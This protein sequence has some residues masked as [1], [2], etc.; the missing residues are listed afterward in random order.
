[1]DKNFIK[2][3]NSKKFSKNNIKTD[4]RNVSSG[5]VF[6]A[7]KG[8]AHDG[9]DH[10][11]EVIK[12]G[13]SCVICEHSLS[14]LDEKD[15]KKIIVTED[16]REALACLAKSF[17]NDPSG[18]L[19]TVGVTGTNGKT[20]TVF[21]LDSI[22][23]MAGKKCGMIS[24]VY[25]KTNGDKLERS[26]MTTPDI[27]TTNRLLEEMVQNGKK[28]AVIEMSSHALDQKRVWGIELDAAIFTNITPEHLD[29]HKN[30]ERYLK[31][32]SKIFKNLKKCGKAVLNID[33]VMVAGL[34]REK[35]F[36]GLVT[37]GVEQDADIKA[38][39]IELSRTG[40][41]FDICT[42]KTGKKF[43][44]NTTLVGLHNVYHILGVTACLI[45]GFV[46]QAKI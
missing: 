7:I 6:I 2:I 38:E 45:D 28:A 35:D 3:I 40:T 41:K 39:N 36:P 20:T 16:T 12:K 33:D 24:T 13:A 31:D 30:M 25:L 29:Y 18:S 46:A 4:S 1:M 23:N 44:M 9:H 10:V 17:Y 19:L 32:K 11:R 26:S 14:G 22:L 43:G 5:D 37:F 21:L 27:I 42:R 15:L 34:A 8:T